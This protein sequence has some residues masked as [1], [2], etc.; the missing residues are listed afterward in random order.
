MNE[1]LIK[2]LKETV[3]KLNEFKSTGVQILIQIKIEDLEEIIEDLIY[4]I[5]NT[6]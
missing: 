4:D 3:S 1:D 2:H 5:D 6:F